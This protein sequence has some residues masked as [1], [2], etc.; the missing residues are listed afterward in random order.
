MRLHSAVKLAGRSF[1]SP[2][3]F[4][5]FRHELQSCSQMFTNLKVSDSSASGGSSSG[6]CS[7]RSDP[8]ESPRE[9]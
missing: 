9:P 6:N 3:T 7:T 8:A 1:L 4:F 2:G 5:F